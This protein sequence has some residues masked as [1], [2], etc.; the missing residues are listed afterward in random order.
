M[1][2]SFSI[3][4]P[5]ITERNHSNRDACAH[6]VIRARPFQSRSG[7]ARGTLIAGACGTSQRGRCRELI[8]SFAR[9]LS[10]SF[11]RQVLVFSVN[12]VVVGV[13]VEVERQGLT[14]GGC[15]T[16]LWE[17]SGRAQTSNWTVGS[18]SKGVWFHPLA[19]TPHAVRSC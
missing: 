4:I 14:G 12:H 11:G 17:A 19:L 8:D 15:S 18:G 6:F 7:C 1:I 13:D 9:Y 3:R 16:Y 10:D 5:I 2:I